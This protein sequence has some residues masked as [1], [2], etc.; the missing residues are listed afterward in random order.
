MWVEVKLQVRHRFTRI[1]SAQLGWTYNRCVPTAGFSN[2]LSSRVT[3]KLGD[4]W[5]LW[6]GVAIQADA[7]IDRPSQRTATDP[8][9]SFSGLATVGVELTL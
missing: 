2:V 7:P 3:V 8:Q 1:V 6:G 4:S 9:R 5:R